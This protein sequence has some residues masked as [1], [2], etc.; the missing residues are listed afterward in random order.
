MGNGGERARKAAETRAENKEKARRESERLTKETAGQYF[1]V[2]RQQLTY[3][4]NR[5]SKCKA[6]STHQ[7]WYVSVS[8]KK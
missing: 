2:F 7:P 3:H 8:G 5:R 1:I 4:W 6:Q